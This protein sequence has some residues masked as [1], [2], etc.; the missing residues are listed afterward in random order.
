MIKSNTKGFDA[1]PPGGL[2]FTALVTAR[3]KVHRCLQNIQ[4]C[5]LAGRGR[6]QIAGRM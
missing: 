3:N 4:K 6:L 2:V 1:M 5:K